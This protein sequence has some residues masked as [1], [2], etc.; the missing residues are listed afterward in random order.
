MLRRRLRSA[1]YIDWAN[2]NPQFPSGTFVDSLPAWLPWLED[3]KF[4]PTGRRRSFVEMRA[5]INGN[6]LRHVPALEAAGFEVIPS[7]DDMLIALDMADSAAGD[8]GIREY[9]LFTV[10]EEF[11]HLLERLGERGKLRAVTVA[12]GQASAKAFPPRSEIIIPLDRLR[13]AFPYRRST[14]FGKL[15]S[16]YLR[17]QIF[18]AFLENP[19]YIGLA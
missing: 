11:V 8:N 13:S 12:E 1:L 5:Y 6:Y 16:V 2:I 4:D 9:I 15:G 7:S 3:G 19:R 10:D 17:K 14:F 18:G